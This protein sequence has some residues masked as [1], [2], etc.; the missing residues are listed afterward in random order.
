MTSNKCFLINLDKVTNSKQ[1]ILLKFVEE[2]LKNIYVI[3][4]SSN[5]SNVIDT[6]KN[7]CFCLSLDRYSKETLKNFIDTSYSI[8][9]IILIE[10]IC[11]TPGQILSLNGIDVR[12][13]KSFAD[14]V[15]DKMPIANLPNALSISDKVAFK[16][17]KNKYDV[18]L[19]YKILIQS[20]ITKVIDGNSLA[21]RM[22]DCIRVHKYLNEKPGIDQKLNFDN[23]IVTLWQLARKSDDN[24]GT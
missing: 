14:K 9:D 20:A 22:F 5:I 3:L 8:E 7:R 11:E 13:M 10:S 23:M 12:S 1:N 15:I 6:I 18:N 17:E 19:F 4:L 21:N 16:G 2:P 24:T